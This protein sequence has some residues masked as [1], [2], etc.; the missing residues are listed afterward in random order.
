MQDMYRR[1]L[2]AFWASQPGEL[3]ADE[4]IEDIFSGG[5][6]WGKN[7]RPQIAELKQEKQKGAGTFA[8]SR[9]GSGTTTP[10]PQDGGGDPPKMAQT[11][12]RGM[13][14]RHHHKH[15]KAKKNGPRKGQGEVNEEDVRDDLV[16]WRIGDAAFV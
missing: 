10:N 16:S 13:M 11:T 1:T 9:P 2:A 12:G 3:R 15:S 4:C 5:D 14:G 7:G 6:G 8:G